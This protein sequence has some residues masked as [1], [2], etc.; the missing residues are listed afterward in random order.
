VAYAS[1]LALALKVVG[2]F[3]IQFVL[4]ADARVHVIEVNPRASRTVPVMS[5]IT[6]IPMVDVA[7]KLMF[8][9]TL[10]ALGFA[11][12][13]APD[14]EFVVVKAPV[15]SFSK[16]AN[17]DTFLGPEMKS[18]GEVMGVDRDYGAA[19]YKALLASGLTIPPSGRVCCPSRTATSA[20]ARRSRERSPDGGTRCAPPRIRMRRS[21]RG[22][23]RGASAPGPC[24]RDIVEDRIA[25]V[26]NTRRAERSRTAS[27]FCSGAPRSNTTCPA[28]RRSTRSTRRFRCLTASSR[29]AR[30]RQRARR[31]FGRIRRPR[32]AG[33]TFGRRSYR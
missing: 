28:S 29:R 25:L 26:I 11:P 16:M 7:T 19:L 30:R 17:V 12:G 10:K 27:G 18:T 33:L 20:N 31:V 6:G 22:N 32:D 2:L 21:Q 14:T 15:F 24:H 9:H 3:N 8:G 5:K 13:L 1:K 4:D 23:F